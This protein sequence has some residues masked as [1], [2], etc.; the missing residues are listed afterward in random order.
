MRRARAPVRTKIQGG[1]LVLGVPK[2]GL[3]N[4]FL[5]YNFRIHAL[6]TLVHP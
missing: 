6:W 2:K 5:T 3:Q 1:T 4:Y